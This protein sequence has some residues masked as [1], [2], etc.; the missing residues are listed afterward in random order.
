MADATKP[1]LTYFA[2]H[3]KADPIR[4]LLSKAGVEFNNVT[5]TFDEWGA[6]KASGKYPTGQVPLW[7][8]PDGRKMNQAF[9]ILR[10]LGRQHGFYDGGDLEESLIV[11]WVLETSI[12]LQVSKAYAVQ[13]FGS[14]DAAAIEAA[15]AN[16]SKF[17]KQISEKL[18]SRGKPF[19]AGDRLTIADF[20]VLSHY[21]CLAFNDA[22]EH[23]VVAAHAEA[24]RGE[25]IVMEYL[26]RVKAE[27]A[28][29]L[30]TRSTTFPC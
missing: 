27:V 2:L 30:A 20:V 6:A 26:E 11:D 22:C 18:T 28:P 9:A 23:A 12:D 15:K 8:T 19:I 24:A 21:L 13:L 10:Y 29:F 25:G 1:T 16:F 17:N 7:E 14:T 4:M 5:L 3:A